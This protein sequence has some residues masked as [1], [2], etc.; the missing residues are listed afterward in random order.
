MLSVKP[1]AEADNNRDLDILR[2]SQKLSLILFY[3]T[4][5]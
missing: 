3:Y 1:K 2:I 5:F 4:S